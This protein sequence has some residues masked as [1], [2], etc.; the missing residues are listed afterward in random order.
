MK[1]L[2]KPENQA[3]ANVIKSVLEEHGII[4]EIKSFHDTAYDGLFQAQYGWGQILVH[5]SD[6]TEAQRIVEEWRNSTPEELP[7]NKEA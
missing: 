4:A 5:D 2:M 7:W 1:T 3:E 6:F